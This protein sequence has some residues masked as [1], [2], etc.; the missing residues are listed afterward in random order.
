MTLPLRQLPRPDRPD[1][2]IAAI[3]L[4]G[5]AHALA[6]QLGYGVNLDG[7]CVIITPLPTYP[8]SRIRTGQ[9]VSGEAALWRV[10]FDPS[11]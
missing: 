10:E 8:I 3:A 2:L 1:P 6:R 5:A 9:F 4:L 11:E 7:K